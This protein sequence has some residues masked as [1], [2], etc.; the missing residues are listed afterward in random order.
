MPHRPQSAVSF[1]RIAAALALC[2]AAGTAAAQ[3]LDLWGVL[4]KEPQ[5]QVLPGDGGT[6]TE[7][8]P[9]LDGDA[10]SVLAAPDPRLP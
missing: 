10:E 5:G 1:R 7:A 9:C 4:P 8:V 6:G 3:S 2:L